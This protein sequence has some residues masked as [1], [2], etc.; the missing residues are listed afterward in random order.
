MIAA[1]YRGASDA[2]VDDGAIEL[3]GPIDPVLAGVERSVEVRVENRGSDWWAP[4]GFHVSNVFVSYRWHAPDGAIV[5]G[6]GLRTPLPVGVPPGGSELVAVDVIPPSNPG[7][8]SLGL[9]LVREHV[10]WFGC[11]LRVDVDVLRVPTVGV[12]VDPA[13]LL[14]RR[15]CRPCSHRGRAGARLTLLARDP[16]STSAA[17]GYPAAADP[18]AEALGDPPLRLLL[19]ATRSAGRSVIPQEATSFDSSSSRE[20]RGWPARRA[21]RGSRARRLHACPRAAGRRDRGGRWRGVG[22]ARPRWP[23]HDPRAPPRRWS[24]RTRSGV[25]SRSGCRRAARSIIA[26]RRPRGLP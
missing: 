5:A 9:D 6:E 23:D 19:A 2:V 4:G 12:L 15:R 3:V 16:G 8:Y 24:G 1:A 18:T 11:E 14:D 20:P 26:G 25:G 13:D 7:R 21:T 22:V 17:T 10:H